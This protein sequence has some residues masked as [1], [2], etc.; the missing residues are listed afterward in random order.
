[1]GVYLA[2]RTC[3]TQLCVRN[4]KFI[5]MKE[6]IGPFKSEVNICHL[7]IGVEIQGVRNVKNMDDNL[8]R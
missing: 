4:W 7:F 5:Q 8:M 3:G 1:M 2:L 6:Y